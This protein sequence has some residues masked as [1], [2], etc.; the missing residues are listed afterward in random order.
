MYKVNKIVT[1]LNTITQCR[2]KCAASAWQITDP[3]LFQD[4]ANLNQCV[5]KT[6]NPFFNQHIKKAK[7]LYFQ[8]GNDRAHIAD[9]SL[10]IVHEV[11]WRT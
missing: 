2:S 11:Y 7:Y 6:L 8:Q 1:T 3:V 4:T 5:S 10:A 9:M